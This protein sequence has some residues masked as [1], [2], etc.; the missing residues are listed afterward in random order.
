MYFQHIDKCIKQN[1]FITQIDL[2]QVKH[3]N[4][5]HSFTNTVS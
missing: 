3:I 4:K 2:S 5:H 1:I